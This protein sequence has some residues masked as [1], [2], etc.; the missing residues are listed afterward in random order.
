[1]QHEVTLTRGFWIGETEVTQG[2]WRE[3]MAS[4]PSF[5][6]GCGDDCPVERVSWYDAVAFANRLS[7]AAG[8]DTCYAL[9]QCD[10]AVGGGCE[11]SAMGA[12][13][14][15]AGGF[16]CRSVRFAGLGCRGYR[17]PTEAEWEYAARAGTTSPIYT[18]SVRYLG[19][20]HGPEL[21]AIAWYGGNSRA[22]YAGAWDCSGWGEKQIPA[23][24]C[25]AQ[26]VARKRANP[27]H[28]HDM[29]GNVWEWIWDAPGPYPTGPTTDPEGAAPGAYRMRRGCGWSNIP[30]HCRAADRDDDEPHLR[31]RNW[32]FRIVRSAAP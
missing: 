27:W 32:G 4:S 28:L 29:I 11:A 17:L 20:N 21:D 23:E 7:E 8:L 25:S 6:T 9:E 12:G 13:D 14:W 1:V 2:Q 5:L 16:S 18:G 22:D 30:Q 19:L 24:R 26:P 15:C 31:D 10:G 3:L